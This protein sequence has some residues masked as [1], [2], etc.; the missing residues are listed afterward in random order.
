M[1][2]FPPA[3]TALALLLASLPALARD[4][5]V[6]SADLSA[7]RWCY[8]QIQDQ[9]IHSIRPNAAGML[10][11]ELYDSEHTRVGVYVGTWQLDKNA[12]LN[13]NRAANY[14]SRFETGSG[15][16]RILLTTIDQQPAQ[17]I[18]LVACD[19]GIPSASNL[20]PARPS[21]E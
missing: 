20:P 9:L 12:Y 14:R 19:T 1:R 3:T 7:H 6:T 16:L 5:P 8:R 4:E 13:L 10:T 18:T 2:T 15:G 11:T 17:T 21:L